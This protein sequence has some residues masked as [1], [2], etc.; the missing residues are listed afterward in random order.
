MGFAMAPGTPRRARPR[1]QGLERLLSETQD[2]VAR[3]LQENRF[4]KAQNKRLAD[5]LERVSQ[6][7]DEVRR[8]ARSAPNIRRR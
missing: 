8:L 7:L 6:G 4:L 5:E 2:M 1:S 3:V